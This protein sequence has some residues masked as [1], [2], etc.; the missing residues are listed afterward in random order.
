MYSLHKAGLASNEFIASCRTN[1]RGGATLSF[2]IQG[3]QHETSSAAVSNHKP[4]SRGHAQQPSNKCWAALSRVS[5]A[6]PKFVVV[7][8]DALAEQSL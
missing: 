5:V 2:T 4:P 1:S 6:K 7:S 8:V 3:Q